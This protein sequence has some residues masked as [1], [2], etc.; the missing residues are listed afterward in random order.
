ME[1][2]KDTILCIELELPNDKVDK[3]KV[4]DSEWKNLQRQLVH[5]L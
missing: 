3:D 4:A 5:E 1:G 2:L